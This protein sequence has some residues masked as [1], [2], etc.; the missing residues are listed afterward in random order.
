M[1]YSDYLKKVQSG[2]PLAQ[3]NMPPVLREIQN[4]YLPDDQKLPMPKA[5]QTMAN[6]EKTVRTRLITGADEPLR[7]HDYREDNPGRIFDT[8]KRDPKRK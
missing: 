5:A 6:E 3:G 2:Q 7:Q 4:Q 1:P 8:G